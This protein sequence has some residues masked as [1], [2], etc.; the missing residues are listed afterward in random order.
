VA[1]LRIEP[2]DPLPSGPVDDDAMMPAD[3]GA[4]GP[5]PLQLLLEVQAHDLALDRLAYRLRELPE[6]AYLNE[7]GR[8]QADLEHRRSEVEA[9]RDELAKEQ[10]QLEEHTQ[11]LVSRILVI[12]GRLR[13]GAA[14][15]FRDEQAMAA[16]TESLDR[17]RREAEDQELEIMEQLEPVESELAAVREELAQVNSERV[18]VSAAAG[19]TA[20]AIET[21]RQA[22]AA[23]RAPLAAS[24]P[25]ALA[26][27]YERLR[28]KLGGIGAAKL[29]DGVCSGCHLRLPYR[30]RDLIVHSPSGTIFHCDQCE[31]IL[32]P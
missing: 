21:E 9:R 10:Q 23:E 30:E 13:A 19:D 27:T 24:L 4:I 18:A 32:V 6:H 12:D 2:S 11:A 31:R 7:L 29:V 8:R 3:E 15:S 20:A 1:W 14:G 25:P 22:V 16:E 26:V 28:S 5:D 17:Q